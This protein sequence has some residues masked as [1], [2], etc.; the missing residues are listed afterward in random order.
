MSF[1][2]SVRRSIH[3]AS[4]LLL[5][6]V[7]SVSPISDSRAVFAQLQ[8]SNAQEVL[9]WLSGDGTLTAPHLIPVNP[10]TFRVQAT[11][12]SSTVLARV[13]ERF[14]P[15]QLLSLTNQARLEAQQSELALSDRLVQAARQKALDMAVRGY[16]EHFRPGDQKAP[17]DFIRETGYAYRVAGENLARGFQTAEGI[18]QAWLQSPTHRANLLSP[19]YTQVGYASIAV[20]DGQGETVLLTVQMFGTPQ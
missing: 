5:G 15:D 17:W 3:A 7:V 20:V 13:E 6:L 8:E 18:T 2:G 12:E 1:P 16:W 14:Q 9:T 4:S 19:Y 10:G 11:G